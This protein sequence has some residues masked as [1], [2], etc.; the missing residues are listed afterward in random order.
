MPL[1]DVK[2]GR[3]NPEECWGVGPDGE[4]LPFGW[5]GYIE[6]GAES[7]ILFLDEAGRPKLFWDERDENGGVIGDP[8]ELAA[9]A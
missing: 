5:S 3:Y 1:P 8:I 4:H 6:D 9:V 7:W 2:I